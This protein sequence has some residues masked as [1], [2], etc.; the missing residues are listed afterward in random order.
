MKVAPS[1]L[2][3]VMRA[4]EVDSLRD[5]LGGGQVLSGPRSSRS[6]RTVS[7][8]AT[9]QPRTPTGRTAASKSK[10]AELQESDEEDDVGEEDTTMNDFDEIGAEAEG[11]TDDQEDDEEEEEE[12]DDG[13]VDMDDGP[14]PA[15][16]PLPHPTKK[17]TNLPRPPKIT[18]KT[19]AKKGTATTKQALKPSVIVTPTDVG[20]VRS[21]EDQEIAEDEDDDREDLEDSE[22]PEDE[23]VEEELDNTNVTGEDLDD[24]TNLDIDDDDDDLS[25]SLSGDESGTHDPAK[26][27]ARQRRHGE[28]ELMSL[29][30]AP[31]QRKFFTDAEKAMK[32]DE[33]ARKRKELTKRKT[34]EEKTAALNR[35][36]K[37]QVSKSRGAAPKAETLAAQMAAAGVGLGAGEED[38]LPEQ[39]ADPLYTR[40]VSNKDG[41][42][43]GVPEEWLGKK[44]G[45]YFGP[46]LPAGRMVMEVE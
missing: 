20:P 6:A 8:T 46:P 36:L 33:H 27:T 5:T 40:W 3:E 11:D 21:V 41:V 43:L 2:R 25:D 12:D 30:M 38:T 16:A 39:K 7:A 22:M 26:L 15:P 9:S 28:Q 4:N 13:D 29:D 14:A 34:Q 10:Y 45:T 44:V 1:K 23:E 18:L 37:P 17:N 24:A 31:Q 42:R 35:L 32:K 19:P